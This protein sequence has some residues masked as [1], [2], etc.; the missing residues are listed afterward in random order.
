MGPRQLLG[1]G[2]QS[3]CAADQRQGAAAGP[4]A[5][6]LDRRNDAPLRVGLSAR[7]RHLPAGRRGLKPGQGPVPRSKSAGPRSDSGPSPLAGVDQRAEPANHPIGQYAVQWTLPRP[8][9]RNHERGQLRSC[10]P[11]TRLLAT[12]LCCLL[13]GQEASDLRCSPRRPWPDA[14]QVFLLMACMQGNGGTSQTC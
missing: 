9:A 4:R 11:H 12:L 7:Q 3:R 2:R 5:G 6:W 13:V 8:L 14:E 10:V 1:Q